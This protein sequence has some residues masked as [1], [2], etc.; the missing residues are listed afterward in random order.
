MVSN[1]L[2]ESVAAL[3][4]SELHVE[5]FG[6]TGTQ[7]YNYAI[8]INIDTIILNWWFRLFRSVVS[9]LK[10]FRTPVKSMRDV[11]RRR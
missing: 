5:G 11:L 9:I 8:E 4:L 7:Q 6:V 10:E 3:W 2:G 1:V